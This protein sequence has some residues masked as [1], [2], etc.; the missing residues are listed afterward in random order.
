MIRDIAE[1]AEGSGGGGRDGGGHGDDN[2]NSVTSSK[3][4][5]GRKTRETVRAVATADGGIELEVSDGANNTC[6]A[7]QH[8][9]SD[10]CSNGP[11]SMQLQ[12]AALL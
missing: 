5:I 6:R 11:I 4:R 10:S 1:T 8:G 2:S 9:T 12:S 7:A 3:S